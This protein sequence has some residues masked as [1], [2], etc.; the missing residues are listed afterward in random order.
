[1]GGI[2]IVVD[3]VG[4]ALGFGRGRGREGE[5]RRLKLVFDWLSIAFLRGGRKSF[6]EME[7]MSRYLKSINS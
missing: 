4:V 6:L 7:R 2:W 1:M 3:V 5:G